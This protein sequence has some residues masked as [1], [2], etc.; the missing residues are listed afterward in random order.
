MIIIDNTNELQ[1][2]AGAVGTLAATRIVTG[3]AVICIVISI[4]AIISVS[5]RGMVDI[6]IRIVISIAIAG[7]SGIMVFWCF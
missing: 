3:V 7:I 1:H 4:S 2:R 5:I 6:V